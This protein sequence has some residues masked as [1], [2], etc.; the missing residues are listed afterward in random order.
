MLK[1]RPQWDS[2]GDGPVGRRLGLNQVG[3]WDPDPIGLE[4]LQERH[5]DVSSEGDTWGHREE[6]AV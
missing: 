4:S 2:P 5:Q 3:V 6:T 1:P